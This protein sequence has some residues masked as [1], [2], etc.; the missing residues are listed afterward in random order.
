MF[1][2]VG[3]PVAAESAEDTN[4]PPCLLLLA[5]E[6]CESV[7]WLP[8]PLPVPLPGKAKDDRPEADPDDGSDETELKFC[9]VP[10]A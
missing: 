10:V 7:E 9:K 4:D 6:T 2:L 1:I 8:T 5:L 3:R